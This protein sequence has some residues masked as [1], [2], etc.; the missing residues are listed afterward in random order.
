MRAAF[1]RAAMVAAL[2]F[3]GFAPRSDASRLPAVGGS[4]MTSFITPDTPRHGHRH[5]K[6]LYPRRSSVCTL[7][8]DGPSVRTSSII[9]A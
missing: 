9:A 7:T 2:W 3:P 8:A 4:A 5:F 6:G 1:V